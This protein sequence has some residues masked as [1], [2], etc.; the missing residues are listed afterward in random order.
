MNANYFYELGAFIVVWMLINYSTNQAF[1]KI[2]CYRQ[3]T[4]DDPVLGSF[5]LWNMFIKWAISITLFCCLACWITLKL[6]RII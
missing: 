1:L 4:K 3:R 5:L 2:I 6:F